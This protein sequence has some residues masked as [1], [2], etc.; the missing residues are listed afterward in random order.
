M[1]APLRILGLLAALL[2]PFATASAL[3]KVT[4]QLKWT[5]CFQFAGYYAA[6]A[7]GYYRDAGLDVHFAE[8]LPGLDVVDQVVSGQAQYGVGT[9][10]LLLA[11]AGGK[12]VVVLGVILQHS[13]LIMIMRQQREGESIHDL[14]GKRVM[15][16]PEADEIYAY[17]KRE[18]IDPARFE[19]VEHSFDVKE[20][21]GGQVA[22][23]TAYVSN[24]PELLARSG[25]PYSIFTPRSAGIDFY[26]D[27]LFTAEQEIN[28]HPERVRAFREASLRG[29]QYA[30]AHPDEIIDLI[31]QHYAGTDTR[32][33]YAFEAA[34][35]MPLIRPDL[36]EV[37][38]MNPGRWRHIADVYAEVGV[39][40]PGVALDGFLYD[41]APVRYPVWVVAGLIAAIAL[42]ALVAA[43]ATYIHRVNQ[44]L[45]HSLRDVR[46][47]QERLQAL[48]QA[49]EHS[50]TSIVI[51][52]PDSAIEY[53]NPFFTRETGYSAE[54]AHGR[55]PSFLQ[56][57]L[58]DEATFRDMWEHLARGEPW[59][60]ELVNR[61]KSG[62]LYWEEAHVAPVK[63]AAGRITHYVA[64]KLN[65]TARRETQQRLAYL[66]HHDDL[67]GLPNRALFFDRLAHAVSLSH[68]NGRRVA[69]MYIDL[70]RFKPINDTWGH[71]VGDEVLREVAQRMT[72]CVRATDT[73]G[74][75]GGDEFVVLLLDVDGDEQVIAVA[76]KIR[77]ALNEPF[78]IGELQLT[79]SSS[80]GVAI[81][82][83]HGGC[84]I[85]LARNADLAM[86]CAKE[87]GR[88]KVRLYSPGMHT[89][90]PPADTGEGERLTGLLLSTT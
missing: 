58:T 70:D 18:G 90:A 65:I 88:N 54:E 6:K 74:R 39:L 66:A 55:N 34:Q 20:L 1:T 36:L 67:T 31:V 42:A 81:A 84:E 43:I 69:L 25:I 38:Y 60:G 37:G 53:V 16:E 50:P 79:I 49:I 9:S 57:G 7:K 78:L 59:T 85:E 68:R 15:I 72:G 26:A 3:E 80:T 22:A 52:G 71:A 47:A 83:Q 45:V 27:N 35:L 11:R 17:L 56:S 41:P 75:I 13:P 8:G 12:P 46:Q 87:D 77:H 61:R 33:H 2:W 44:R 30:L 29:W 21:I 23:M 62:E 14:V 28:D 73:V 24:E 86:Y 63:D 76:E 82:P 51:T 89:L 32:A 4:L 40:P 48:S 5:H 10:S 19:R 64:V